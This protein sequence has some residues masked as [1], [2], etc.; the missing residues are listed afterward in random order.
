MSLFLVRSLCL[1]CWFSSPD[2]SGVPDLDGLLGLLERVGIW[3]LIILQTWRLLLCDWLLNWSFL[4]FLNLPNSI[5]WLTHLE[6]WVGRCS[7]LTV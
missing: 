4:L 3:S 1:W 5:L 6:A 2:F 7:Q